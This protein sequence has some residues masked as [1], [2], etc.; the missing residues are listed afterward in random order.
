MTAGKVTN[1]ILHIIF[2]I[3]LVMMI[4]PILLTVSVSFSSTGSNHRKRLFADTERVQPGVLQI[5]I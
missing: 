2:I 3:V 4:F 1:I 5:H